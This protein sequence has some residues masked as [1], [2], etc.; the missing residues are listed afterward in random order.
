MQQILKNEFEFKR[1]PIENHLPLCV[2]LSNHFQR[3]LC[4][5]ISFSVTCPFR[6]FRH[7]LWSW[8]VQSRRLCIMHTNFQHLFS[9]AVV[10]SIVSEDCVAI[11]E[12]AFASSTANGARRDIDSFMRAD[13]S[14]MTMA[15]QIK[16]PLIHCWF[17]SVVISFECA[18]S[19]CLGI[20]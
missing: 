10:W 15:A 17:N 11:W 6:I 14:F 1:I 4:K 18:P 5:I 2:P 20:D 3:S 19:L 13:T 12:F 8:N 16:A 9:N 7:P